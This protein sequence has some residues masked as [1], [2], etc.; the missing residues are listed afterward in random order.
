MLVLLTCA[1][2]VAIVL[3]SITIPE[4]T[5]IK[6]KLESL[7]A[8]TGTLITGPPGTDGSDGE[9][10]VAGTPGDPGED[11][12]DGAPGVAGAQGP[13]GVAGLSGPI[14]PPGAV[15]APGTN[16]P[17]GPTGPRG[18]NGPPGA[19]G[20][21]GI[22]GTP[23]TP[24]V[25]GVNGTNGTNGSPGAVGDPGPVGPPGPPGV[26][27]TDGINGTNGSPG[28]VGAPGPVGAPGANGINTSPDTLSYYLTRI[29]DTTISGVWLNPLPLTVIFVRVG[30]LVTIQITNRTRSAS[31]NDAL[32]QDIALDY[33][34]P[35]DLEPESCDNGIRPCYV[36]IPI[37]NTATSATEP[38]YMLVGPG[39]QIR[40]QTGEF[41]GFLKNGA[42][43]GLHPCIGHYIAKL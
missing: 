20:P 35:P 39:P 8:E 23:G 15:G 4:V 31:L 7:I 17:P 2:I 34:L 1:A 29:V 36:S 22:A 24:G 40:F 42:T 26:D 28:D 37:S 19:P 27:G 18:F 32:T 38:G 10:G 16:G 30:N 43:G 21:D 11:G 25:D 12:I 6:Q 14:G 33:V 13:P 3:S 5:Q 41:G 9:P